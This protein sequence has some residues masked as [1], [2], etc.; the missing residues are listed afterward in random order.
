MPKVRESD[1]ASTNKTQIKK[2]D[3]DLL[4]IEKKKL[5]NLLGHIIKFLPMKKSR[6]SDHSLDSS[7]ATVEMPFSIFK[8]EIGSL[9]FPSPTLAALLQQD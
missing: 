9:L 8:K 4:V 3:G 1:D 7:E 2:K 6:V 5:I